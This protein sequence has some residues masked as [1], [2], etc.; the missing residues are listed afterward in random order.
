MSAP[1]QK[2]GLKTRAAIQVV[3]ANRLLDGVV[4]YL[5]GHGGWTERLGLATPVS[6]APALEAA[7]ATGKQAEA[8]RV[9]L[10]AYPID[11]ERAG[12]GFRPTRLREAIR[13]AGPTVRRDLARPTGA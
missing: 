7:V 4:V 2:S 6:G 1:I 8:D 12:D 13:A 11:V 10:D 9:V 3:T 5:D